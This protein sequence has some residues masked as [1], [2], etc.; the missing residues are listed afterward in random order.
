MHIVYG[1]AGRLFNTLF[2][3]QDGDQQQHG[4]PLQTSHHDSSEFSQGHA[5][6][7]TQTA[8]MGAPAAGAD[9]IAE[10]GSADAADAA[11]NSAEHASRDGQTGYGGPSNRPATHAAFAPG[12]HDMPVH[13]HLILPVMPAQLCC[14]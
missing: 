9:R 4:P 1:P 8:A 6:A 11:D 14:V 3:S 5:Q 7:G 12:M 2:G 13:S 10:A